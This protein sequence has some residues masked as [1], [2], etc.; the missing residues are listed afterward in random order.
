MR[1]E[2][3]HWI[4]V[5]SRG[6]VGGLQHRSGRCCLSCV[7][8]VLA[9][10]FCVVLAACSRAPRT[11]GGVSGAAQRVLAYAAVNV[12]TARV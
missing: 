8:T 9:M 7:R 10:L 1:T 6:H 3:D 11:A 5:S 12:A 4:T 2:P